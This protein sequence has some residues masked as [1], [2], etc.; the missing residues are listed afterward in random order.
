MDG[1]SLDGRSPVGVELLGRN[2]TE[3]LVGMLLVDV[4]HCEQFVSVSGPLTRARESRHAMVAPALSV[5]MV[6]QVLVTS[7]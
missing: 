5:R 2:A 4:V 7:R 6:A 1:Q 3:C